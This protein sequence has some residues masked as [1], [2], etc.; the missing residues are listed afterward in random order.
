MRA[1]TTRG[2]VE[3]GHNI[4]QVENHRSK[5]LQLLDEFNI[6]TCHEDITLCIDVLEENGPVVW[7]M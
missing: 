4:R 3:K 5:R 1:T 6:L 2:T 7:D